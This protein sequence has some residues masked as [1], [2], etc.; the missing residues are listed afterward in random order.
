MPLRVT[1]GLHIWRYV[2]MAPCGEADHAG[3]NAKGFLLLRVV[4]PFGSKLGT[5]P[6]RPVVH[7]LSSLP[8]R[9]THLNGTEGCI[10]LPDAGDLA[11][12]LRTSGRPFVPLCHIAYTSSCG[13][14]RSV[15]FRSCARRSAPSRA[16]LGACVGG[17]CLTR[18]DVSR[19]ARFGSRRR[20]G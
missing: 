15:C 7:G 8:R 19:V 10:A 12:G 1:D 2:T 17:N 9:A 11:L 18:D 16:P 20:T 3:A 14:L 6:Y 4:S 13:L 5:D